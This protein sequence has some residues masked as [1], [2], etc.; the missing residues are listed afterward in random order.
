MT[1]FA[2]VVRSQRPDANLGRWQRVSRSG[3]VVVC[4][5]MSQAVRLAIQVGCQLH[6]QPGGTGL[7]DARYADWLLRHHAR[8]E[9][10]EITGQREMTFGEWALGWRPAEADLLSGASSPGIASLD[11]PTP[12][13]LAGSF[14]AHSFH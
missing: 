2:V 11:S 13:S 1:G 7:N 14:L 8:I 3:W 12:G 10:Y 4:A 9:T 5:D 6:P